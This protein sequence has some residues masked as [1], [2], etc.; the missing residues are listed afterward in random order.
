MELVSG[1]ESKLFQK[2]SSSGRQTN[3]NVG[4]HTF[5]HKDWATPDLE[6]AMMLSFLPLSTA[7]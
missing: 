4:R 3:S 7:R 2:R 6:Y 1:G 5:L